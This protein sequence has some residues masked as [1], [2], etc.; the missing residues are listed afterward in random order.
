MIIRWKVEDGYVG[1]ARPQET[2]IDDRDL[3]E[4]AT[5]DEQMSLIEQSVQEDYEQRISWAFSNF[6]RIEEDLK[7]IGTL[8]D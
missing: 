2:E 6:K 4:C 1:G 8:D 7:E 5:R 3:R